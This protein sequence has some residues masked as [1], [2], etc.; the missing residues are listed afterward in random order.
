[1][2]NKKRIL[3][4]ILLY[5]IY[6]LFA[7]ASLVF[8]NH[9]YLISTAGII[10]VVLIFERSFILTALKPLNPFCHWN[11]EKY[12]FQKKNDLKGY[13]ARLRRREKFLVILGLLLFVI[14]IIVYLTSV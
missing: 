7:I 11:G 3:I 5:C 4:N 9:N 13:E 14:G 12:L 2:N 6:S 10:S 8:L 1:M